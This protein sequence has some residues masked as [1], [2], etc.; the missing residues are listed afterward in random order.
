MYSHIQSIKPVKTYCGVSIIVP[1][2]NAECY[3]EEC[4]DSL[5]KQTLKEIEII[6]IDDGSTD[7]T[8]RIAEDYAGRDKR[9]RVVHQVN[10]GLSAA[11]NRGI[12]LA[13]GKY[14]T[15]VDSDDKVKAPAYACLYHKAETL[16]A[17]VVLGT[18]FRYTAEGR[19][20]RIGVNESFFEENQ[21]MDGKICL[22]KLIETGEYLPMVCMNL[23][24]TAFIH[25]YNLRFRYLY[26]ED[27]YFSPCVLYYAGRVTGVKEKFY[28]YRQHAVSIMHAA[29]RRKRAESVGEVAGGLF[30][31]AESCMG[32][33]KEKV[34]FVL[35]QRALFLYIHMVWL[36]STLSED[37][38]PILCVPPL[39]CYKLK[40]WKK[41]L[42]FYDYSRLNIFYCSLLDRLNNLLDRKEK[43]AS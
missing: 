15:F 8:G 3:L 9:V 33:D 10:Q 31:F 4:L 20:L 21:V 41:E 13:Q 11:R 28:F 36:Y 18:M 35:L 32:K 19:C 6:V 17:D 26:H 39:K 40:A 34:V 1:A 22:V 16:K 25:K 24:R 30:D 7:K 2:Y 5:L 37:G 14:V 12:E 27:E 23:Y 29:D 43:D 42:D 38:Q